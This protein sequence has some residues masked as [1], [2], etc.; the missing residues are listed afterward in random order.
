MKY[1]IGNYV[2]GNY[3]VIGINRQ[4][5]KGRNAKD[6]QFF[7]Y[8]IENNNDVQH[9]KAAEVK[10]IPLTKNELIKLGFRGAEN[11]NTLWLQNFSVIVYESGVQ[12][13]CGITGI[14]YIKYVHQLQNIY[15]T[16][17]GERELTWKK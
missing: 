4:N 11:S 12:V 9:L 13:N 5:I 10:P 2:N 3:I 16:N 15:Y 17:A 1:N 6:T 7:T 14:D 8:L